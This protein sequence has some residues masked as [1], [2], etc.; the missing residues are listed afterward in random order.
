MD[1]NNVRLETPFDA[2]VLL[3]ATVIVALLY[4]AFRA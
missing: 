1:D 2:F 4:L 3:M